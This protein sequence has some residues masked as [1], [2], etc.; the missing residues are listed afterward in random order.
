[1]RFR[2]VGLLSQTATTSE[3]SNWSRFLTT[4]GPQYPYPITPNLITGLPFPLCI[5]PFEA[6]SEGGVTGCR[7]V[8][9]YER[10]LQ[11]APSPNTTATGVRSRIFRSIHGDQVLAYRKSRRTMSSNLIRLRPFTCHS[12]V[13]PGLASSTRRR[14]QMS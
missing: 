4:L 1:M 8:D 9:I 5:D 12:P 13:I 14:C 2:A 6:G 7:T 11:Y 10:L 3:P